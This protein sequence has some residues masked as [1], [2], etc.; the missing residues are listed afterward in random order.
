MAMV[1]IGVAWLCGEML[2]AWAFIGMIG[3]LLAV[4]LMLHLLQKDTEHSYSPGETLATLA[5]GWA[6]VPVLAAVSLGIA[7]FLVAENDAASIF[8]DPVNCLFES[9]SGFTSTGLTMVSDPSLLPATLQFWRSFMEWV[10]GV[11]LALL[12]MTVLNPSS[13]GG[14]LFNAELNKSFAGNARRTAKD[15]WWIYVLLSLFSIGLFAG[16]GMPLWESVNH[17]M[18]AI[19]T[20]GFTITKGSFD[21]YATSIQL[22]AII[23]MM[24][25]SISFAAYHQLVV[26][27]ECLS[28]CR[29]APTLFL[30]SGIFTVSF[31]LWRYQ[32]V[33]TVDDS[34]PTLL[35][36]ATSAFSTTG[37]TTTP[38]SDWHSTTLILL[39]FCLFIGGA[40]GATTGGVK[41]DRILLLLRGIAWRYERLFRGEIRR[42]IFING[43][44][45]DRNQARLQVEGAAT[46]LTLWLL[47]GIVG[48][49]IMVPIG[50]GKWSFTQILF[51]VMSALG[52]AGLSAGIVGIDLPD[53]GKWTFIALMWLGRLELIAAFALLLMPFARKSK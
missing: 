24:L 2:L 3:A 11:G 12:M 10:G 13:D 21:H 30:I 1:M 17:G 36:Q 5:L 26:K 32:R 38:L 47:T 41:I 25:G 42:E 27:R 35:F 33:F 6:L 44:T 16:L 46:L 18:T 52:S 28:F 37:F 40:S 20:G 4:I 43:E 22:A 34:Y 9:V 49:L 15:I 48:C 51:D 50:I 53:L 23:I 29:R 14:D 45:Y 31:L 39:I 7:G 19:S 8:R